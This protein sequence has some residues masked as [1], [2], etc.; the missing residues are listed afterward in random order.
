VNALNGSIVDTITIKG[1][2]Y[3]KHHLQ[4]SDLRND[5]I[6]DVVVT[7]KH[8]SN[9]RVAIAAIN[10]TT[11]AFEH[12]AIK[13]VKAK[14]AQVNTTTVV[15][16]TIDLRSKRL[17]LVSLLVTKQHKLVKLLK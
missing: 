7:S 17:P 9:V 14:Q 12:T 10:L 16:N 8:G 6:Q 4:L 15:N 5:D 2:G 11:A 13:V 3:T 1:K